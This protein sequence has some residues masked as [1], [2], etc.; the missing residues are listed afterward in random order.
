MPAKRA[1]VKHQ[2]VAHG[3]PLGRADF[4][5]HDPGGACDLGA[6]QIEAREL[7][8]ARRN[9]PQ[10]RRAQDA[11]EDRTSIGQCNE[12]HVARLALVMFERLAPLHGLAAADRDLLW[13]AAMLHGI[14]RFVAESGHHKHAAY[15]IRATPLSGWRD[16]E[17]ALIAL[18]ARYYRK[19]IPKPAHAEYAAQA[20]A[21]RHRVDVLAGLLRIADGLD[22]R[23]LGLVT[24]VSA[25]PEGG[26]VRITAQAE[27]DVSGELDAATSKAD[28]FERT[29]GVRVVLDSVDALRQAQGDPA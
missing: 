25:V 5:I 29:F 19:A 9:L 7:T 10:C 15:L 13:A 8:D 23:H 4:D 21:D 1:G 28:L 14:G 17:R 26:V 18:I 24:D 2:P 11:L 16:D 3:A 27:G 12:R 22:I 20:A 6:D